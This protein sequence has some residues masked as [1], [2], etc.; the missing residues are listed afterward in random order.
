MDLIDKCSECHPLMFE[1]VDGLE[2][3]YTNIE[4]QLFALA[5]ESP[6]NHKISTDRTMTT[7]PQFHIPPPIAD[8]DFECGRL[9]PLSYSPEAISDALF[10]YISP[11]RCHDW[12]KF[13]VRQRRA[14]T[15]FQ[16]QGTWNLGNPDN[17]DDVKK[18]FEIFD[19]AFFGGLLKGFCKLELVLEPWIFRRLGIKTGGYCTRYNPGKARDPRYQLE[20]PHVVITLV[21]YVKLFRTCHPCKA[22]ARIEE[23]LVC[24]LHEMIHALFDIY[25]CQCENGCKQKT[26][27]QATPGGHHMPRQFAAKAIESVNSGRPAGTSFLLGLRLDL[28][29]EGGLVGDLLLGYPMPD[30]ETLKKLKFDKEELMDKLDDAQLDKAEA[31]RRLKRE[32]MPSKFNACVRDECIVDGWEKSFGYASRDYDRVQHVYDEPIGESAVERWKK[33]TI[34]TEYCDEIWELWDSFNRTRAI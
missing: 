18:Y 17:I 28:R 8:G 21:E 12:S 29:R 22:T 32:L 34:E 10:K 31:D 33:R 14:I 6:I 5:C 23:Y 9:K 3:R 30:D 27:R 16:G 19:D 7:P 2:R 24:L 13:S 15:K 4:S 11:G 26:L 25:S 1:F 20:K